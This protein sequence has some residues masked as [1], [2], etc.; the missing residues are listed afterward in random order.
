LDETEIIAG[1]QAVSTTR[2]GEAW[3]FQGGEG[4]FFYVLP[5]SEKHGLPFLGLNTEELDPADFATAPE[6]RLLG[7][8][9][10]GDFF[11]YEVDAFGVPTVHMDSADPAPDTY[12]PPIGTHVHMNWA[13]SEPGEYEVSFELAATLTGDTPVTSSPQVVKFHVTGQAEFLHEGHADIGLAYDSEHGA[14]FFVAGEEEGHEHEL[15]P[16]SLIREEEEHEHA[17]ERHPSE[18]V[19]LLGGHATSLVPGNPAFAFLGE[20]G[21][22]LYLSPQQEKEGVP[23]IGWDTDEVESTLLSGEIEIELHHAEGPGDVF[24]YGIDE[25]GAPFVLWDSSDAEEDIF[26]LPAGTHR[27]LNLAVTVPGIYEL[28]LHAVLPLAAG[29]TTEAET[30]LTV[31]AGGLEGFFGHISREFPNWISAEVGGLLYTPA[32][33]W[34]WNPAEGW[35]YAYGSGGPAQLFYRSSD[36]AWIWTNEEMYPEYF[37]FRLGMTRTWGD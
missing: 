5:Q 21:D 8:D 2:S 1:P 34:A 19:V 3:S 32:W 16:A 30:V 18:V 12:A 14:S 10:P 17:G 15:Q 31:Q 29:G 24:L 27:H 7:V 25:Q 11:L 20:P 23:F 35:I 22:M 28:E 37:D 13:F 33:P 9:G 6:V 36:S 4:R 26:P